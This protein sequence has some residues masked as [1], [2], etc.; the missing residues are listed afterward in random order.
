MESW[1]R[2]LH[3]GIEQLS[4]HDP[5]RALKFFKTA[6]EGCPALKGRELARL[7][8]YLGITLIRLGMADSA[9]KSWLT[10]RKIYKNSYSAKMVKRFTNQYGMAK[11]NSD[12]MDDWKAFYAIQLKKYIRNKKSGRMSTFAE[13]DM[14]HDLIYEY[15]KRLKDSGVLNEKTCYEKIRIFRKMKI[16]FP[17]MLVPDTT[18]EKLV[19]VSFYKK[20][21]LVGNDRCYCGSGLSF[22]VCCGRTPGEREILNGLF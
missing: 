12:E 8:F 3:K 22:G 19:P 21:R 7:L 14:V 15:W 4:R 11:Q 20:R 5:V 9:L 16:I 6:L 2:D 17:S 13:R 10:A 18:E 1:K